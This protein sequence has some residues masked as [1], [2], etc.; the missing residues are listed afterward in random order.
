M[1]SDGHFQA[2]HAS[3]REAVLD[4]LMNI[5]DGDY[6]SDVINDY[7]III[8]RDLSEYCCQEW[9]EIVGLFVQ[10]GTLEYVELPD[11]IPKACQCS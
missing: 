6:F 9:D 2:A 8:K 3:D 1:D 4:L 7:N 10:R 5:S 11:M